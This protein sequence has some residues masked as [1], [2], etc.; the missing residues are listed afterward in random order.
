MQPPSYY[1]SIDFMKLYMHSDR[2]LLLPVDVNFLGAM[3]FERILKISP[4]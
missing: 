2:K 4:L 3:V 1:G